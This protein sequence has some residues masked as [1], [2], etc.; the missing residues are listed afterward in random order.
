M[1]AVDPAA[2][3][4]PNPLEGEGT[5]RGLTLHAASFAAG[6]RDALPDPLDEGLAEER[7]APVM[8]M[9]EGLV[10]AAPGD[11]V[12]RHQPAHPA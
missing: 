6:A 12:T 7:G 3:E 1:D 11:G 5:E 9:D 2:V 8:P 10:A 4:H